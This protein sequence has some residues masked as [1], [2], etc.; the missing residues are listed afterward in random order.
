LIYNCGCIFEE[1]EE[2][3]PIEEHL[4]KERKEL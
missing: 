1:K 4:D 3:N 2:E